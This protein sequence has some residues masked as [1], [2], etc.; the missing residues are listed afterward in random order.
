VACA[1]QSKPNIE[2]IGEAIS[3]HCS[4]ITQDEGM[5][6]LLSNNIRR[7]SSHTSKKEKFDFF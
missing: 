1:K 2:K 7:G 5:I 4:V 6:Q 3:I